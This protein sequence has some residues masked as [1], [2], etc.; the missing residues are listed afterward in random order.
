MES[1]YAAKMPDRQFR[2]GGA[3][4]GFSLKQAQHNILHQLLGG[5]ACIGGDL[6][7]LRFLLRGEMYFHRLQDNGKASLQASSK[8]D[9][10]LDSATT[11]DN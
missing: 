10:K 6:R 7:K 4:V 5:G 2:S 11:T 9:S 1:T 3:K 8:L